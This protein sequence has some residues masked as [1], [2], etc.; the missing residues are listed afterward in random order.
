M[1]TSLFLGLAIFTACWLLHVL[2]W[3]IHRPVA[4]PIWLPVIFLIFPAACAMAMAGTD[5]PMPYQCDTASIMTAF[6]LHGAISS[7]YICG[8]A[9]IIEYSPSAEILRIVND[10]MPE[11]IELETLNISTLSEQALTGKRIRHLIDGQMVLSKNGTLSLAPRGRAIVAVCRAY[12][13]V[14]GLKHR[15]Q[16]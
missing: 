14:F 12:R 6:L 8:Y 2:I 9:G 16:G 10:S 7:C 5:L 4:Y 11:G 3:R 1:E 13:I 15:P